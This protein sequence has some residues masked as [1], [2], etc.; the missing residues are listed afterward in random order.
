[1]I[2]GK[3]NQG[4][5]NANYQPLIFWDFS[6]KGKFQEKTTYNVNNTGR[7]QRLSNIINNYSKKILDYGIATNK[8][9]TSGKK[10]R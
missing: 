6:L 9:K 2:R 5:L 7:N 1:L 8:T 3:L 4:K 10:V